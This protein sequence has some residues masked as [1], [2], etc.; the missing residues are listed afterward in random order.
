[1]TG[2]GHHELGIK[3]SKDPVA[4]AGKQVG[5]FAKAAKLFEPDELDHEDFPEF[6]TLDAYEYIDESLICA[7]SDQFD[8][9][10]E[11]P[12]IIDPLLAIVAFAMGGVDR[13]QFRADEFRPLRAAGLPFWSS[14]AAAVPPGTMPG[15][16]ASFSRPS[17]T[18]N[19][20]F[21]KT[22]F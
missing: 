13:V 2:A 5:E 16:A 10:A 11:G 22:G 1:M 15:S 21:S 8:G 12:A 18:E 17:S 19:L 14:L 20:R 6:L 4:K 7:G 3:P 9:E